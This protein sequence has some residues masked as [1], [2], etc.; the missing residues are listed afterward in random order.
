[1]RATLSHTLQYTRIHRLVH[2]LTLSDTHPNTPTPPPLFDRSDE[3]DRQ[4]EER[5][6]EERR[7]VEESRK[8]QSSYDL[9]PSGLSQYSSSGGGQEKS[10]DGYGTYAR[11]YASNNNNNNGNGNRDNG[12]MQGN[13]LSRWVGCYH[14]LSWVIP[15]SLVHCLNT[16]S[17]RHPFQG[18]GKRDYGSCRGYI[19]LTSPYHPY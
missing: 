4:R 13:Y 9:P 12:N 16:P 18:R 10:T 7:K 15:Y 11:G 3:R 14:I 17:R 19:N 1:M 2:N 6:E 5:R 8:Q